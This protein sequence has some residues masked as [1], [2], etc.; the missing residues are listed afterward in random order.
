MAHTRRTCAWRT[1]CKCTC[2]CMHHSLQGTGRSHIQCSM[3]S[4]KETTHHGGASCAGQHAQHAHPA[5]QPQHTHLHAR[6]SCLCD[7]PADQAGSIWLRAPLRGGAWLVSWANVLRHHMVPCV[8]VAMRS[9]CRKP[10]SA[11]PPCLGSPVGWKCAPCVHAPCVCVRA[12]MHVR[13]TREQAHN[14]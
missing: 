6:A 13:A 4:G 14:R 1:W 9:P 2:T 8:V 12:C 3:Y 7:V 11:C 5:V 10:P